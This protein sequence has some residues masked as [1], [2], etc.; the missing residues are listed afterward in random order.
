MLNRHSPDPGKAG[1]AQL[2]SYST[3]STSQGPALKSWDISDELSGYRGPCLDFTGPNS[4]DFGEAAV[5]IILPRV[6]TAHLHSG[7]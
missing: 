7:S 6:T 1:R 2:R 5:W 4:R 3:D